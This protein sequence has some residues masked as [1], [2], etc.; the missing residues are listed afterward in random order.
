MECDNPLTERVLHWI[1]DTCSRK[2]GSTVDIH[3]SSDIGSSIT[4][5][6]SVTCVSEGKWNQFA[7][8]T[9]NDNCHEGNNIV[10]ICESHSNN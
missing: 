7:T 3:C 2:E 6:T 9:V 10:L 4:L 5:N 8:S 1:S